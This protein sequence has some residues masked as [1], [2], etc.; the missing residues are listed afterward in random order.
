MKTPA[1][2]LVALVA[3]L[4]SA[5]SPAQSLPGAAASFSA[6]P[7]AATKTEAILGTSS[8]LSAILAQQ[9]GQAAE[10][11]ASAAAPLAPAGRGLASSLM[12]PAVPRG[13]VAAD[14]PDIFGSVALPVGS[15]PLSHRWSAVRGAGPGGI[16]TAFAARLAIEPEWRRLDAV[17]RYVNQRVR[18][19]DDRARFRVADRWAAAAETLTSARGDCE[20]YAIAKLQMLRR[21]GFADRDLYLAIVKDLV[22]RADHAVLVVRSGGR[23]WV[24]DNGTDQVIDSA[25]IRDYRPVLTFSAGRAWSHGYRRTAPAPVDAPISVA[26]LSR[27]AQPEVAAAPLTLAAVDQRSLSASLLAFSTGF[28]R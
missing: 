1:L 21:A 6:S 4:A 3:I 22:R 26:S 16:A 5:P 9:G 20:D 27:P 13:P 15:T 2:S 17:N 19:V 8:R 24:L 28:N 23:F 10:A 25:D 12:I 11:S 14:Q 18:F 7:Y